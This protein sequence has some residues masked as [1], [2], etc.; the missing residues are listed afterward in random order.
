MSARKA[1]E[2]T[3]E[4]RGLLL[5]VGGCVSKHAQRFTFTFAM[6]QS[7]SMTWESTRPYGLQAR[8]ISPVRAHANSREIVQVGGHTETFFELADGTLLKLVK[9]GEIEFYSTIIHKLPSI[10]DFMPLCHGHGVMPARPGVDK[11]P[12]EF[13]VLQNV[14]GAM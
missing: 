11:A 2:K 6:S 13:V 3:R 4:S 9:S 7:V 5:A 10:P 8:C 14:V 1:A 12:R